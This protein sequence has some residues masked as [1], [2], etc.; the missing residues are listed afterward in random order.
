MTRY[1]GLSMSSL[2]W[3]EA[4]IEALKGSGPL[5]VPDVL[6]RI[7][8][9][10]LRE[11]TG[12]TP[13]AT[14]GAVLYVALENG[15]DRIRLCGPGLFEHTGSK[16]AP[17]ASVASLDRLEEIDI[18][19][20]WKNEASDFTP[21]LLANAEYLGEILGI[22]VELDEKEKAVGDFSL[23]LIG[24]DI[25]NACVLIVENQLSETDHKHLGQLLT[26]AAGTD[27]A[28]IIWV[29]PSFR[30]EHRRA[31]NYL[32]DKSSGD[33]RFFGVEVRVVRIGNSSPA[34]MFHLVSKPADSGNQVAISGDANGLSPQ[35][36]KYRMFWAKYLEA[37]HLSHPNITNVRSAATRTFA[38]MN[39][40]RRGVTLV[41]GFIAPKSRIFAEIYIDLKS[42]SKNLDVLL[43]LKASQQDIEK[44]MGS[45]LFWDEIPGKRACR[46]R[47]LHDGHID[48]VSKH[49]EMIQWLM[50]AQVG[51]KKV[52]R[53]RLEALSSEI[54]DR[55]DS[56]MEDDE[57]DLK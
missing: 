55:E 1:G 40:L 15:D 12:Q 43:T 31:L 56:A 27:A 50:E 24:R 30:D 11:I 6:K 22:D 5:S 17:L 7:E 21:W 14:I 4:A 39:Y 54:W 16:S 29:A 10:E 45:E 46:I 32:N 18:R 51:L 37:V 9:L 3:R 49:V 28:T 44:E 23:D 20:V 47:I 2:S 35:R 34:P 33:V 48:D 42:K 38:H 13:E 52:F 36:E 53:P 19:S 26:Y 8:A 25:S 41:L 57:E